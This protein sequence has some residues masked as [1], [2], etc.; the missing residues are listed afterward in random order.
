MKN[1][2]FFLSL[3]IFCISCN[4]QTKNESFESFYDKFLN[5]SSFQINRIVFPLPGGYLSAGDR[6]PSD[7]AKELGI[8]VEE[9]KE[10][11]WEKDGWIALKKIDLDTTIYKTEIKRIN[12]SVVHVRDYIKASGFEVIGHYKQKENKWYLVYYDESNF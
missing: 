4:A 6:I 3:I 2:V 7:V 5:D 10:Y 1:T 11:Y 9:E 12:D 8:E